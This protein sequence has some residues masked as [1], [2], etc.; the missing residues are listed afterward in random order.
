MVLPDQAPVHRVLKAARRR[1]GWTQWQL[2]K[3]I[4]VS[5]AA[6]SRFETSGSG[7]S[8]ERVAAIAAALGVDLHSIPQ[9]LIPPDPSP[10]PPVL[11]YCPNVHCPSNIP[12]VI[13]DE[14]AY[15]PSMIRTARAQFYGADCGEVLLSQCPA[16][17]APVTQG[18]F[19]TQC[20]QA[21]VSPPPSAAPRVEDLEEWADTARARLR[22]L[23]RMSEVRD[24]GQTKGGPRNSR[25]SERSKQASTN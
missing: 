13:G 18:A 4:S 20:G 23:R 25:G 14:V 10:L 9:D 17:K 11:Y 12:C 19:C 15:A 21:R 3:A 8:Q 5:Q 7:L 24:R 16:C 22:E 1:Q 2:A 6:I